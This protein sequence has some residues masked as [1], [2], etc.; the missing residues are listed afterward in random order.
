MASARAQRRPLRIGLL[1]LTEPPP[2]AV[3]ALRDS[4]DQA[5]YGPGPDLVV[6]M[7]WPAGSQSLAE[8]A[9]A[10]V[11]AAPDVIVAWTT[12]AALAAKQATATIPIVVVG[13]ADPVRV[14]LV[15]SLARPGGNVTGFS[16]LGGDLAAKQVE[17]FVQTLPGAKRLGVVYNAGSPAGVLQFQGVQDALGKLNVPSLAEKAARPDQYRD[18]LARLAQANVDGVLFVPDASTI[19]DRIGIA[20]QA[21]Q[22]RL[23]TMF[24]R[25]ENVEA[26]GLMSYG[27]DLT[28]QFRQ[29]ASYVDRILKGAKPADLPVQQPDKIELVINARI[30]KALDVALPPVLVARA[31]EVIE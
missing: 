26:G 25:R 20:E 5:G 29:V 13:I 7:R 12:P 6:D 16:N 4:L 28:D 31:D 10:V 15:A 27:P 19:E 24:Q 3:K 14:G 11:Q 22:L 18:A 8:L 17:V 23:P 1:V 9:K 21:R 2:K 30:A